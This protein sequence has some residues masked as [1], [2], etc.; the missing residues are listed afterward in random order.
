MTMSYDH[1]GN[2]NSVEWND[3]MERWN[4]LLE[5]STGLDYLSATPTNYLDMRIQHTKSYLEVQGLH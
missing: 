3:G 2:V 4:G 5:W 1:A